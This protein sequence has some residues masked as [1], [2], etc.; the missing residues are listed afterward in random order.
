MIS[1]KDSIKINAPAEKV[2]NWLMN[3]GTGKDYQAWHPDH[4]DCQWVKGKPFQKDSVALFQ[5][6]LH[7]KLH[8]LRFKCTKVMS[9]R[10]IEYKP[11]FPMSILMSRSQFV[12][13]PRGARSCTFTAVIIFRE[14]PFFKKL[15]NKQMEELKQHMKEEDENMRS[16]IEGT[17]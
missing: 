10:L 8:R 11:S 13:E 16:I 14:G 9:N 2:F 12:I 5:E 15:F 4:V 1:I 3:I 17:A 6:Y 7:G